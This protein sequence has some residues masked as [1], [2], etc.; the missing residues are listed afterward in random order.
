MALVDT[1]RIRPPKAPNLPIASGQYNQQAENMYSNILRLYFNA[2]DNMAEA[3][4]G[5]VGGASIR[6]PYGAFQDTVSHTVVANTA[7]V[8]TFNTT[9]LANSVSIVGGSKLTVVY[10]GIYSIQFSTQ[11]QN[12]D[13]APQDVSIWLRINGVDVP[14]S[15]GILGFPARKSAVD[16]YHDIKG[17][18]FFLAL[19]AADYVELYWATTNANVTIQ[20]YP[21]GTGPTRP[22][23]ASNV[24]TLTFV[25]ALPA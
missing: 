6:T 1:L 20:A 14:G 3:L 24:V 15:T 10:A 21:L 7:N 13:V 16:P 22:S 12:L 8:M 9:D 5:A 2:I 23:T 25:S 11:F 18:N 19:N 4:L 17:W